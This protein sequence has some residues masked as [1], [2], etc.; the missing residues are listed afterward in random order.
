MAWTTPL[1][2]DA[3]LG[4]TG[5]PDLHNQVKANI[6]ELRTAVDAIPAPTAAPT[7]DTLSGATAVGKSVLKAANA[8]D[9]R[10]A[11]G[12]GTSNLAL[13]TTASTA[14]AGNTSIPSIP[15][16]LSAADAQA[17]TATAGRLITAKVLA[18]EIDRRVAAAIAAI[19]AG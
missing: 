9:A 14:M 10:T 17:G 6:E 19:P 13:G 5:H 2:K 8:G 15:A 18:D 4:D 7:A 1:P 12:A 3:V 11:I 16:A